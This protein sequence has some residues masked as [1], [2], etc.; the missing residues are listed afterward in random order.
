M[1]SSLFLLG[2]PPRSGGKARRLYACGSRRVKRGISGAPHGD[3][4]GLIGLV[5][6]KR[7]IPNV[8]LPSC[9]RRSGP[10]PLESE[11]STG[12]CGYCGKPSM[13]ACGTCGQPAAD[14]C[15]SP[16]PLVFSALTNQLWTTAAREIENTRSGPHIH[17]GTL[18]GCWSLTGWSS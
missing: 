1:F 15:W 5:M 17:L 14:H 18:L 3:Q 2:A 13:H 9:S 12:I 4:R 10:T 8:C 11:K 16:R 6:P 7:R